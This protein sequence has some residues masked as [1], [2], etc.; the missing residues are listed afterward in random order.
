M[1]ARLGRADGSMGIAGFTL[2]ESG[3]EGVP[4]LVFGGFFFVIL[5]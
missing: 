2:T 1:L 4:E 3:P 5:T